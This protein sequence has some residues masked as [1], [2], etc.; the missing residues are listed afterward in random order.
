M[1]RTVWRV[2]E[3]QARNKGY[4]TAL[5]YSGIEYSY[6]ELLKLSERLAGAL[7]A[8]GMEKGDRAMI[9]MPHCP[10][11]VISWFALQ[12]LGA[13]AVPVSHLYGPEE[14]GYIAKDSGSKLL[15]CAETNL[16]RLEGLVRDGLFQYLVLAHTTSH[17]SWWK[18]LVDGPSSREI[19]G[20]HPQI[21]SFDRLLEEAGSV[22]NIPVQPQD[23]MEI[24]YT[25][26][27]TGLPKGVPYS[28][29][30]F[31]YFTEIERDT[32]AKVL[33]R[34]KGII[35][36]GSPLNHVLGQA[37]GLSFLLSGDTLVLMPKMDIDK[38]LEH[39]ERFRVTSLFGTPT[40]YRMILEHPNVDTYDLSSIVWCYSGGDYLPPA[41]HM[42]WKQRTGI[43]LF[44]GYGSTEA[45]GGIV[46]T[47]GD[48]VIPEGS[49]GK[50]IPSWQVMLV[51]PET[52]AVVN[53]PGQG[54]LLIS[55]EYMV[56]GY[57]NKP[58][59]TEKAFINLHGKLWYR[60]G[61][62]IR[63]DDQGWVYYVDRLGDIIKHKG[64]RVVPSK[65]ERVLISH[66]RVAAA[67]VIGIPDHEFGEK[68]KA[69]VVRKALVEA[70]ELS[71]WCK[72]RLAPYEV[73]HWIEFVQTLPTSPSGKV[74]RKIVRE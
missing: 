36:Q 62:I 28:N 63:I 17:L 50:V 74:L 31:L 35:L 64:Y 38:V 23:I 27:T 4:K 11:W 37:Q 2:F 51:D 32:V 39:I 72:E 21:K 60:T 16:E 45:C 54:E 24:L 65:I 71:N 14:I 9:S 58:E 5:I 43:Y 10:Q 48:E 73:P 6:S 66:P 22:P 20:L 42:R 67:C 41:L 40:F 15:F 69:L 33:P 61:D 59:E 44:Q 68:I 47:P 8:L 25:S 13:V 12:R 29:E 18:S 1:E 70:S 57:W 49:L 56:R 46:I 55:S 3:G 30:T 52:M 19:L 7:W 26:G 34:G 53:L